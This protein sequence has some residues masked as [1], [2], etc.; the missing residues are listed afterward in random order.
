MLIYEYILKFSLRLFPFARVPFTR[1]C[2]LTVCF[3]VFAQMCKAQYF[4]NKRINKHRAWRIRTNIP[5]CFMFGSLFVK[6]FL[7]C[8]YCCF[9]VTFTLYFRYFTLSLVRILWILTVQDYSLLSSLFARYYKIYYDISIWHINIW[10]TWKI[11][12]SGVKATRSA[13]K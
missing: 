8:F 6:L 10:H 5:P 12:S 3:W 4:K 2:L 1:V 11:R 13:E 9:P 7:I